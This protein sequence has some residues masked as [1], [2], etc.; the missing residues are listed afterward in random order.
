MCMRVI[1]E[2]PSWA[3]LLVV[4][5]TATPAACQ[6]A[7]SPEGL[8]GLEQVLVK[9][10]ARVE[11]SVVAIARYR[12]SS[13]V[14]LDAAGAPRRPLFPRAPDPKTPGHPD[15][16]P[17]EYG[18]GLLVVAPGK[19]DRHLVLTCYHVVRGGLP[20][21][22][23][24]RKSPAAKPPPDRL[25]V[26]FSSR[27]GCAARIFAADP[28]S[29]LAV[30]EFDSRDLQQSGI[31][32]RKL[33]P[34]SLS[35]APPPRKGQFVLMLGNPFAIARDGSASVGWGLISNIGR[36]P[37]GA[38]SRD[39][40]GQ[41]IH[42]LGT[43]L[44]FDS[45][46][47][48]GSSGGPV[49]DLKGRLLGLTTSIAPLDGIETASGFA[50]PMSPAMLRIINTLLAGLEVE[51]GFLG[52]QPDDVSSRQLQEYSRPFPQASAARA[53]RVFPTSP[54]ARAGLI[55]GDL[56]LSINAR[57]VTN[58]YDLMREVGL[59]EPGR[60]ITLSVWRESTREQ[61][62]LVGALGKWP[63]EDEESIV[64]SRKRHA[65]WRGLVVDFPT[66]RRRFL[67]ST[68][69]YVRAVVV[70]ELVADSPAAAA[71]IEVGDFIAV[72]D[73]TPVETPAGFF[74][75]VDSRRGDVSLQLL[76]GRRVTLAP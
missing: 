73:K 43:L 6:P 11:P 3:A 32:T 63:V 49:L 54:A 44:Q 31:D 4:A 9:V 68:F 47:K 8:L 74:A 62:Q 27:R 39:E 36:F 35:S 21:V 34:L 2:R 71:G 1:L 38:T 15:F 40:S 7:T 75:A 45:R 29:D 60:K 58:R 42:E 70:S 65:P 23:P 61:L 66:A 26:R 25:H 37:A 76:D 20:G 50:I 30:L 72:V 69:R 28:R 64:A 17:N 22:S 55:A 46:L 57:P 5:V 13:D 14:R 10:T 41:T 59:C 53:A 18:T 48:H 12:L 19:P 56:I 51:Y 24:D 16:I 67:P 52:I 33:K